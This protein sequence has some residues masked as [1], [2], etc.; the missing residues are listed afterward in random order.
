MPAGTELEIVDQLD[1]A[2]LGLPHSRIYRVRLRP[3]AVGSFGDDLVH[4]GGPPRLLQK[5][6]DGTVEL[7][8][9]FFRRID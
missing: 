6:P 9:D 8:R 4:L 7:S 1:R 3:G 5:N 2:A